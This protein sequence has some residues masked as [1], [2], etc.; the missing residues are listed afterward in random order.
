MFEN[1]STYSSIKTFNKQHLDVSGFCPHTLPIIYSVSYIMHVSCHISCIIFGLSYILYPISYYAHHI[2]T[3]HSLSLIPT[4]ASWWVAHFWRRL[5]FEQRALSELWTFV[6]SVLCVNVT[7]I[8]R[9]SV[10]VLVFICRNENALTLPYNVSFSNNL[11]KH[12]WHSF[13]TSGR[14]WPVLTN[15]LK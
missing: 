8:L 3:Q 15:A 11:S 12:F 10:S 1:I 2:S 14:R 7:A 13:H 4:E 6:I 9:S 5:R